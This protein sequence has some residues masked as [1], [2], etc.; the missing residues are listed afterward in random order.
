MIEFIR[1]ILH[2]MVS[3]FKPRTKLLAEILILR[4]HST[5]FSSWS[6]SSRSPRPCWRRWV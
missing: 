2:I 6:L 4:Q 3:F 1:L 5:C